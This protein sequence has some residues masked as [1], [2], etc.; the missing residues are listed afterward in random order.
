MCDGIICDGFIYKYLWNDLAQAASV[1]HFHY[2][3]HGRSALPNDP[4]RIGIQDFAR[5]LNSVR[6]ALG[7]PDVVLMGHSVGTQVCLEAYRERPEKVRGLVL[8][9]GS[10]GRVTHTF[11]GTDLLA[12]FLPRLT[13]FIEGNPR[14]VRAFWSRVPP[15]LAVRIA[16]MLGEVDGHAIAPEDFIPY[17]DHLAHVDPRLFVRML[18]HAG[19]HSAEDLLPAVDVPVLIVAGDRDSFTPSELSRHMAEQMPKAELLMI[20]GGTHVTPLEHHALVGEHVTEFVARV[21]P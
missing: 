11:H 19:D 20:S 12:Q 14:L 7:D 9:C 10:Y 5:D 15:R 3:G 8:L 2:R 21:A 18:R 16:A 1:A 13:A 6:Y 17:F 4:D